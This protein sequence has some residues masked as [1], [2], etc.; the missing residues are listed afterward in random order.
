MGCQWPPLGDLPYPWIKLTSLISPALEGWFFIT[1]ATWLAHPSLMAVPMVAAP[2]TQK[3]NG[4]YAFPTHLEHLPPWICTEPKSHGRATLISLPR[5]E[6][7]EADTQVQLWITALLS[8]SREAKQKVVSSTTQHHVSFLFLPWSYKVARFRLTKY[9]YENNFHSCTLYQMLSL[10]D[11]GSE[12]QICHTL[13]DALSAKVLGVH[14]HG[15]I[16]RG[17]L[18]LNTAGLQTKKK[19]KIKPSCKHRIKGRN[20]H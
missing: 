7:Q 3:E 17:S 20:P 12:E 8:S 1:S 15:N 11:R 16:Y 10:Q 9:I 13:C 2:V 6:H 14:V 5:S 4:S 19:M 18:L